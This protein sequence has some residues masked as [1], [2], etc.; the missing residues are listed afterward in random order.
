MCNA[1]QMDTLM[2]FEVRQVVGDD[3][4]MTV[5]FGSLGGHKFLFV[6]H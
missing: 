3:R 5:G 4:A 2:P 6:M 1:R